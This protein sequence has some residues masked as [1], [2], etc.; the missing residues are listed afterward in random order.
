MFWETIFKMPRKKEEQ[1]LFSF[2]LS[3]N[4]LVKNGWNSNG[5]PISV[6][7]DSEKILIK[8]GWR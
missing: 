6:Y 8:K 7:I 4:A 3:E 2:Q 1:V 5:R